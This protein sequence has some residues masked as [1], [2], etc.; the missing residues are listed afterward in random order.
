MCYC[1]SNDRKSATGRRKFKLF[2]SFN[3][4]MNELSSN[5]F[6]EVH[7]NNIPVV[8]DLLTLNV[9]P[10]D[11]DIVDGT[12]S[13]NLLD[14]VCRNRKDTTTVY[15]MRATI[16]QFS[17]LLLVLIVTPFSNE[18]SIWSKFELYAVRGQK[19]SIRG[20][21]IELRKL[22]STVRTLFVLNTRVNENSSQSN[23]NQH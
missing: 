22:S 8:K 13:Q 3:N 6:K 18:Y 19:M 12:S 7:L 14:K 11:I 23:K 1:S 21:Y 10:Y 17:N 20:T 16:E 15:V 4:T 9:L 2:A 5:Q